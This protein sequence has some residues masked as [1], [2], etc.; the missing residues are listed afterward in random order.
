M[1]NSIPGERQR[2][3]DVFERKDGTTSGESLAALTESNPDEVADYSVANN[4]NTEPAFKWWVQHTLKRRERIILKMKT[5]YMRTEQKFGIV[6]PK[7]VKEALAIDKETNTTY[8]ADAI[9]KELKFIVPALKI[10]D[11]EMKAP[12]QYQ[13]IT[14]HIAFDVK[15][16]FTRK[17]IFVAGG[18]VT[19][20]PSTQT[21]ASVVS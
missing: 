10:L 18:H 11:P 17:A 12:V 2:L 1:V 20:P 7:S 4:M 15:I 13:D 14:C 8:W 16:D 3:E 6:I 9:K 19:K 5:R 21:Y